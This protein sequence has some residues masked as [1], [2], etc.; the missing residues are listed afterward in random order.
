MGVPRPEPRVKEL[1]LGE[2]IRAK[3]GKG[4]HGRAWPGRKDQLD[5]PMPEAQLNFHGE[6]S[7]TP[8]DIVERLADFIRESVENGLRHVLVITGKGVN[9]KGSPVVKPTVSRELGRLQDVARF[10]IARSFNGG[11]GAFEVQLKTD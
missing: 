8:H 5:W 10:R 9:S 7:L 1:S 3:E 11:G 6:G 4:A 2:S